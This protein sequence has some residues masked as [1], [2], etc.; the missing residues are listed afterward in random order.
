MQKKVR[1]YSQLRYVRS[2]LFASRSPCKNFS[3]KPVLPCARAAPQKLSTLNWMSLSTTPRRRGHNAYQ[4]ST[5][6]YQLNVYS[7]L[8]YVRPGH[9]IQ[10]HRT[11]R[12]GLEP[13]S[14]RRSPPDRQTHAG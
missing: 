11:A 7:Q 8:R 12:Q 6:S 2:Q 1:I 9:Q 3:K 4:L 14:H 10:I 13:L 5:I